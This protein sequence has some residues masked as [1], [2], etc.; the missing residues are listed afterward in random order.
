[1]KIKK[2][3]FHITAFLIVCIWGVTFI[4]TKILL[5]QG[6]SPEMIFFYRFL[7]AYIGIWFLGRKPPFAK[8]IQDEWLFVLLG[9]TGGSFYFLTENKAL[10]YTL[11]S[12]VS[13]LV[14]IAPLLTAILSHLF[15]KN[16]KINQSLLWGTLIALL[17]VTL[18][19]FNGQFILELNPLG[20]LLSLS[21]A[22]S[23]A[24]YTIVLKKI[25]TRYS[26][27]FITRKT[28]FYGLLTLLPL[29]VWKPITIDLSLLLIP[30]I[31]W[32]LLF[33]G[34]LASLICFYFWNRVVKE[35]GAIQTTNYVYLNPVITLIASSLLLS[36]QITAYAI[37]GCITILGGLLI[38]EKKKDK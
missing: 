31:G 28:F 2:G 18:V 32:N 22:F 17:G 10:E 14:C 20:D 15:L 7:I 37:F 36:E 35:L 13:L 12:N 16:E 26:T 11:A 29:F 4:S 6:L 23:W 34:V 19:I 21:A 8:T 27:L 1:M 33:L 5:S 9:I 24:I 30:S 38:A 25:S 3:W